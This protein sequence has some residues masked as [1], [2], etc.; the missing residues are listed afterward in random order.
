MIDFKKWREERKLTQ[1]EAGEFIGASSSYWS[2]L[3]T[4]QEKEKRAQAIKRVLTYYDNH[5]KLLKNTANTLSP[6]VIRDFVVDRRQKTGLNFRQQSLEAYL[7]RTTLGNLSREHERWATVSMMVK[8]IVAAYILKCQNKAP[9][10]PEQNAPAILEIVRVPATPTLPERSFTPANVV[11]KVAGKTVSPPQSDPESFERI[12]HIVVD[13]TPMWLVADVCRAI[14]YSNSRVAKN[15]AREDDVKI[16]TAPDSMGRNVDQ[17][18][19][20]EY[21]LLRILAKANTPMTEPF[22]RWV[23]EEVL[24][25]IRESGSYAPASQQ[26]ANPIDAMIFSLQ[27]LKQVQ[28]RQIEM[29]AELKKLRA[30]TVT[31]EQ[32]NQIAAAK[33]K[34]AQARHRSDLYYLDKHI[35]NAAR[36]LTLKLHGQKTLENREVWSAHHSSK[37]KGINRA[38]RDAVAKNYACHPGQAPGRD[39]YT[40]ADKKT[41]YATLNRW[42]EFNGL[43]T[44]LA[45]TL[46]A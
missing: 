3:E 25:S 19:V 7:G 23:F 42:R 38:I 29:E 37:I 8:N 28:A 9:Q 14:G 27:E 12:E 35:K 44:Q 32:V 17:W 21:G 10:S 5:Q 16:I 39:R 31:T 33:S 36:E 2:R 45:L 43:Q 24:P 6:A 30:S 11:V 40:E 15:L 4:G 18:A 20:N 41:A 13:N 26:P 1:E 34:E 22:E 46:E